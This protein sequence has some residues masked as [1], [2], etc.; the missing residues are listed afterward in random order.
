MAFHCL[1]IFPH[2]F[3]I[4]Q[5]EFS[6]QGSFQV[7]K[8]WGWWLNT[9]GMPPTCERPASWWWR[10]TGVIAVGLR[11]RE[12]KRKSLQ[13][14]GFGPVALEIPKVKF[15]DVA[16]WS[17]GIYLL[18]LSTWPV[19]SWELTPRAPINQWLSQGVPKVE[20]EIPDVKTITFQ[21]VQRMQRGE[22]NC[23]WDSCPLCC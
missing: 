1:L 17:K 3:T 19:S 9:W 4:L 16:A 5:H 11:K 2:S 23:S 10:T 13:S 21:S 12:C 15:I 18:V 22:M 7:P 6:F 8:P 14:G 20:R